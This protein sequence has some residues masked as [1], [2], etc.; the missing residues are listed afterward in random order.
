MVATDFKTWRFIDSGAASGSRN[1]ATDMA[2][3]KHARQPVLRLY[4][5][6]PWAISLGYHQQFSDIDREKCG[7]DGIDIV[8]RPTG[9]RAILHAEE[10][11]YCVIFPTQ[12]TLQASSVNTVYRRISNALLLGLHLY[13]ARSVVPVQSYAEHK[14]YGRNIACF[15]CSV[16]F[17]I[18][19]EKRKL[20]GSAQRRFKEGILQHGSIL[21]GPA[22]E[23]L[24]H[25]LAVKPAPDRALQN[26]AICLQQVLGHKPERIKL[27]QT[28]VAGFEQYFHISFTKSKLTHQE[29][30][31]TDE[32][33]KSFQNGEVLI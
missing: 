19:A 31:Q 23:K 12:H 22:H 11:T 7:R 16:N 9:G 2:L 18:T 13:G 26:Q 4:H 27:K 29:R 28:L 1:M 21:L 10:L 24:L 25:Y 5:W 14:I 17:E 6:Q 8:R 30:T 3:L 33:T 32:L 20:I 15:S